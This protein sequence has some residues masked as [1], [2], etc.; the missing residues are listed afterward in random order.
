MIERARLAW[1]KAAEDALARN[2]STLAVISVDELLRPD[3]HFAR[4]RN[5]GYVVE[6][7]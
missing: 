6:E 1:V 7:P 3:G 4:L 2:A 5:A